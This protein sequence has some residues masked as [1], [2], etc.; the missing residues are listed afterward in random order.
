MCVYINRKK[1]KRGEVEGGEVLTAKTQTRSSIKWQ[2]APTDVFERIA[3]P[4]LRPKDIGVLAVEVFSPVHDVDA[5]SDCLAGADENRGGAVGTAARG[6]GC[7][8]DCFARVYGDGW[9]EAED[10]FVALLGF[11]VYSRERLGE[12]GKRIWG[13]GGGDVPSLM[14]MLR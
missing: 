1:E 14:T 3:L 7:H 13:G 9:I 6:E 5:V 10:L 11:E 2:V 4:P 8:F 12:E